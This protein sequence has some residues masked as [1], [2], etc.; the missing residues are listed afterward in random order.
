MIY[1]YI[2]EDKDCKNVEELSMKMTDEHPKTVICSKCG[3]TCY[4]NF[5]TSSVVIP[6]N[7]KATSDTPWRYDKNPNIHGKKYF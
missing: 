4:R 1:E 3:K 2:C 6:E 5:L 7:M